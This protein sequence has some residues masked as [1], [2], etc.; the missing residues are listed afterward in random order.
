MEIADE[1]TTTFARAYARRFLDTKGDVVASRSTGLVP[2]L[3]LLPERHVS[4]DEVWDVSVSYLRR[5]VLDDDDTCALQHAA[6][7]GLRLNRGGES[8]R[9]ETELAAPARLRLDGWLLPKAAAL[10]VTSDSQRVSV[11]VIQPEKRAA[12][13]VFKRTPRSLKLETGRGATRLP[14]LRPYGC[15]MTLLNGSALDGLR[16][17]GELA[18]S[19]LRPE[20]ISAKIRAS[21]RLL[22]DTAPEYMAWVRM[23]VRAVIPLHAQI[24]EI[25]S[26]SDFDNPGVTQMSFPIRTVALAETWVHECSH[27][28]FQV[29][30]R[31]G[32]VDDGSDTKLYYSPVRLMDRP[33][34]KIL[35]AYHAFANVLL[36]YRACR[37][38]GLTNGYL[39]INEQRLIP[40]LRQLQA[41]LRSTGALTDIGAA[42]FE[43]LAERIGV[44]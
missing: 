37:A 43:P 33:I 2:L 34:D 13:F 38:A 27:Q 8:G 9:W 1:I 7:V 25:R 11:R 23:L 20:Q 32:A 39:E 21:L 19:R 18:L 3:E 26:G 14:A 31:A 28:Q 5:A 22:Q 42:L 44:D 15:T 12:T 4:F 41:P 35:L 6:G 30:T 24:S 17:G 36:F 29:V 10:S 40:Q 16:F